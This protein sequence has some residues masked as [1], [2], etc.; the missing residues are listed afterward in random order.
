MSA[1]TRLGVRARHVN[2]VDLIENGRSQ[3]KPVLIFRSVEELSDYTRE[4]AK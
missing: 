3:G 2:M 4:S 1:D